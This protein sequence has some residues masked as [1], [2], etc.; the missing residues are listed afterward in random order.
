MLAQFALA[1]GTAALTFFEECVRLRVASG[2]FIYGV[3]VSG[4]MS[5]CL[6]RLVSHTGQTTWNQ[7]CAGTDTQNP[8]VTASMCEWGVM[9]T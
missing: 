4:Q 6:D 9:D 5:E 1:N 7:I 8:N 2:S 3:Q